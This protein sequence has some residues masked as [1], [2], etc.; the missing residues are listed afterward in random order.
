MDSSLL[1]RCGLLMDA[2]LVLSLLPPRDGKLV[3][4]RWL[5][6]LAGGK[7]ASHGCLHRAHRAELGGNRCAAAQALVR[8]SIRSAA[9]HHW[10]RP[11]RAIGETLSIRSIQL[12]VVTRCI[13]A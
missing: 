4:G 12:A 7:R 10:C 6:F 13:S 5:A 9:S 3:R 11:R 2:S 1:R 8:A